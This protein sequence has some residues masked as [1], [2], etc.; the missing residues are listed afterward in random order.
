MLKYNKDDLKSRAKELGVVYNTFE[1]VCRLKEVLKFFDE[2]EILRNNLA[3]KGGT[4]INLLFSDL[5]RM[6]VDIDLDLAH[7]FSRNEMM[8]VRETID[9]II[10]KYMAAE[11]YQLSPK[12]KTP[13]SL[14]SFVFE[15]TN[16]VGMKDNIKIEINYS[17]RAHVLPVE[18][19]K[20]SN[21][22]FDEDIFVTTL[23]PVEIYAAKTVALMS[24][25][26]IRDLYDLNH[27]VCYNNFTPKELEDYRKCVIFYLAIA[28]KNTPVC[29]DYKAMDSIVQHD[30]LTKLVPVM[31]GKDPFQLDTAKRNVLEFLS[32]N[33]YLTP[34]DVKFLTNFKAGFYNPQLL[35]KDNETLQ[36]VQN[37]PM[38]M[39]K[40]A[41]IR[42]RE[43]ER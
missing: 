12:S 18:R 10:K 20:L 43:E 24:R 4:A 38:A 35:F 25:T 33:L 21:N 15:Y 22:I 19:R 23:S 16:S 6:S 37:H 3:L 40:T 30:V 17:L 36:R 31:R 1:K 7:N 34:N 8:N 42:D 9:N 28:S 14:D 41:Q 39:W 27:M 2:S 29:L 5:P 32:K 11:G 26:A 13:H